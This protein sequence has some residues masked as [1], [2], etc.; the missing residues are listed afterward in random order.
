M[1]NRKR[2]YLHFH[3]A[4]DYG[5]FWFVLFFPLGPEITARHTMMNK[6]SILL[7]MWITNIYFLN[8]HMNEICKKQYYAVFRENGRFYRLR[9]VSVATI[10]TKGNYQI[11]V[12]IRLTFIR[13]RLRISLLTTTQIMMSLPKT[14]LQ[15]LIDCWSGLWVTC[16]NCRWDASR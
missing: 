11:S 12:T 14:I 5:L 9:N 8:F 2:K 13:C 10:F 1:I 6:I 15:K 7:K 4:P 16:E 3:H